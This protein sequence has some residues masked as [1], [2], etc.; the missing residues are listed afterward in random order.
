MGATMI[1]LLPFFFFLLAAGHV[2][3]FSKEGGSGSCGDCHTLT[4]QEAKGLLRGVDK[5]HKVELSEVPG[6]WV[7]D[8]EKDR[9]RF[10]VYIDFSKSYLIAGN[11]IRLRDNLN[12]SAERQARSNPV[13]ISRIPLGDALLLGSA[14]AKKKAIV[15]TDPE[16]PFCKRLHHEM[17]EVVKRDP[18]IAFWIKLY[19]L[20]MHPNAYATSKSIVCAKSMAMLEA[21]FAGKTVPPPL[22]ETKAIDENIALAA[23]L[24]INSTP[25]LILPDGVIAPGYKKADDLLRLLGSKVTTPAPQR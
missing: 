5:V 10:P 9:Q 16:C 2:H 24:G 19:P 12:I 11:V 6:L 3:A 8:A 7:V 25:T 4:V 22:C 18:D 23:E 17:E 1:K 21:S 20:K 13:D 14:Q 15:F